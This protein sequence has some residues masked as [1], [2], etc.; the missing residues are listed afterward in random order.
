MHVSRVLGCAYISLHALPIIL[1]HEI[2]L[3]QRDYNVVKS[4]MTR[5]FQ[6]HFPVF[7]TDTE[8]FTL[9]VDEKMSTIACS[10]TQGT[11]THCT[12]TIPE[13]VF[14]HFTWVGSLTFNFNQIDLA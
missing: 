12:G 7:L 2:V 9:S 6:H 4:Y 5:V 3:G 14:K 8:S 10:N 1:C 13:A 11:V